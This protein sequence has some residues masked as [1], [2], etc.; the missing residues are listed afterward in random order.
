MAAPLVY[1]SGAA[2]QFALDRAVE[3]L[4][5][6]G[7]EVAASRVI[8]P[9]EPPESWHA[10]MRQAVSLMLTCDYVAVLRGWRNFRGAS[11]ECQIAH[12]LGIPLVPIHEFK[13][14]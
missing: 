11:I 5:S 12:D 13:A 8:N 1:V 9:A 2:N 3:D 4:Q 10:H 14:A 6:L 7:Y